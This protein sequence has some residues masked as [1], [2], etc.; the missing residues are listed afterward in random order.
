MPVEAIDSAS[1]EL[2]Q[3]TSEND[4]LDV[5]VIDPKVQASENG[6]FYSFHVSYNAGNNDEVIYIE[7]TDSD[8]DFYVV[9]ARYSGEKK[10]D[11]TVIRANGGA[12]GNTNVDEVN[13]NS[14]SSNTAD[15]NAR[16]DASGVTGVDD[17][18][19]SRIDDQQTAVFNLTGMI[20]TN[21][22]AVAIRIG[23]G[24]N[25]EAA[26]VGYFK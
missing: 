8:I 7:N 12:A 10:T 1:N 13:W 6:N 14:G 17:V 4:R 16:R 15:V 18:V 2:S 11:V 5:N 24:D 3:I 21:G 20:L 25:C 19:S 23:E 26:I 9:E 22:E